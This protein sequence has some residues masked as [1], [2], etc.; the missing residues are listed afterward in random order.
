MEVRW[1]VNDDNG[2]ETI[3][4]W[5]CTLREPRGANPKSNPNPAA[6]AVTSTTTTTTATTSSSTL[7]AWE[8]HYDAKQDMGFESEVRV[9]RVTGRGMLEDVAGSGEHDD[10]DDVN[11][12]VPEVMKL[13]WRREGEG[14][15][16]DDDSP[17]NSEDEDGDDDDD[18]D[19]TDD[20]NTLRVVDIMGMKP[21]ADGSISLKAV[22]E[23]QRRADE[24]QILSGGE[25]LEEAGNKAF[26]EMP[27]AQQHNIATAFMGLKEGLA[28]AL[29]EL[30]RANG[31]DY[32]I[33]K[34]DIDQVMAQLQQ[35]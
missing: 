30:V 9:A 25:G 34:D 24:K 35:R 3:V 22:H 1:V 21:D 15:N 18:D 23:A 6:A 20:P 32:V 26:A 17:E 5:P 13:R 2:G 11:D 10:V 12:D 28:N 7:T 19:A 16:G 33:T 8:L 27:M 4:W 29:Q 31:P 14:V